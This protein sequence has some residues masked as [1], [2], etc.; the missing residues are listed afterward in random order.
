[1]VQCGLMQTAEPEYRGLKAQ[2]WDLLRGDT[3]SW[4]DRAFYLD[5]IARGGQPVLDVGCGTGRLLLDYLQQ[6]VDIDGVDN[7]AEM[8]GLCRDKAAALGIEPR[9]Y[10]QTMQTLDLPRHYR[11]IIVP[12]SSFQLV[13]D[14]DEART[15]IGR[16]AA[17]LERAGTLVMSFMK[18]RR[19]GQPLSFD[20]T[21]RGEA[22]R[23]EDGATV[24]R[25]LRSR[26]D[27]E[28]QLEHTED[29][30][31]LIVDGEVVRSEYDERSPATR[32]YTLD[33][34]TQLYEHAGLT[35]VHATSGFTFET[36]SAEDGVFCMLGV[37]R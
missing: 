36:A 28:T 5:V 4:P 33:Q 13:T 25:W 27:P 12:S 7:S 10:E 15:A 19:K 9:L 21:R 20:W 14:L 11:T 23:P 26:F 22:Q 30:Y 32:E 34:A 17:H 2:A 24:R 1:M 16:I 6:G 35:D 3:S 37:R 8:L 18:M 29:R 31:E